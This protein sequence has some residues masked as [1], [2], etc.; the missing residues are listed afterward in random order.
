MSEIKIHRSLS[1]Q[2][3]VQ[4][5]SYFEDKEKGVSLQGYSQVTEAN[6]GQLREFIYMCDD[7]K[8]CYETSALRIDWER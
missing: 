4:F 1:R 3:I 6:W 7:F 2:G 8:P 5:L